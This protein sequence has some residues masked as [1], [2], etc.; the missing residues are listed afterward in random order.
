MEWRRF[1][2]WYQPTEALDSGS[3]QNSFPFNRDI[4]PLTT[5]PERKE[6]EREI[7]DKQ[8]FD[9]YM[10]QKLTNENVLFPWTCKQTCHMI[11]TLTS[12]LR[13][14]FQQPS[15]SGYFGVKQPIVLRFTDSFISLLKRFA[16]SFLQRRT[17]DSLM[18]YSL[19]ISELFSM[20]SASATIFSLKTRLYDVRRA[21][22]MIMDWLWM[23]IMTIRW[24]CS[25]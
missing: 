21:F 13:K 25:V 12:L 5:I 3:S 2:L 19:A 14:P 18:P 7:R 11:L 20:A 15:I 1:Q 6:K 23:T 17:M 8:C 9:N 24:S 22:G 4:S 10:Y 16:W